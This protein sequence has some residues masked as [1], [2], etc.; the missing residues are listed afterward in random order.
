MNEIS[1]LDLNID[2]VP[3]PDARN[4]KK[5]SLFAL[6]VPMKELQQANVKSLHDASQNL[7]Q[8]SLSQLRAALYFTQR[9]I[10]NQDGSPS[11][12]EMAQILKAISLIHLR[13]RNSA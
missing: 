1:S 9:I 12:S 6:T 11:S 2:A 8:F 3:L 13:L 4:W 7:E 10:N 5:I